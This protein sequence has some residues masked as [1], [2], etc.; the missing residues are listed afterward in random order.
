MSAQWR[1]LFKK[2]L[3]AHDL[4]IKFQDI[5]GFVGAFSENGL[6]EREEIEYKGWRS[7]NAS[8]L[9]SFSEKVVKEIVAMA[10]T[11]GGLIFIMPPGIHL[12]SVR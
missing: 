6:S 8:N 2:L 12:T 5:V 1:A 9:G 4:E 7:D 11:N 3:Y 10:N